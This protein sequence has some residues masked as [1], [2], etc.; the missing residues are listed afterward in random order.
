MSQVQQEALAV[1]IGHNRFKRLEQRTSFTAASADFEDMSAADF[2]RMMERQ[3]IRE[4]L[5]DLGELEPI[6][7][8]RSR[9]RHD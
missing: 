9:I 2:S 1:A 8:G 4:A 7:F 6:N 3:H 5:L